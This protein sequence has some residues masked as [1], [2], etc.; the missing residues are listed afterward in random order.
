MSGAFRY[1]I[2][3]KIQYLNSLKPLFLDTETTGL[4]ARA[5]VVEIC[6]LDFHGNV[7]L[8]TLVK[9]RLSIPS[10]VVALHGISNDMVSASP[11]WLTVWQE[12]KKILENRAVGI[13]NAEFDLKM[14][15]QSHALSGMPWQAPS[16]QFFCI[17]RL[18]SDF[19]GWMIWLKLEEACHKLG[20]EVR[21]FHRAYADT[22]AARDVFLRL[23]ELASTNR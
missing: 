7:V 23:V 1:S 17:M 21:N 16:A 8:N 6:I 13:Y 11:P 2:L 12:V 10:D 3:E 4:H 15:Q 19:F 5:E 18:I 20:V 14:M 22:L 9:P